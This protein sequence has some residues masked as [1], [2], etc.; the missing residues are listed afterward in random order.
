MARQLPLAYFYP[1]AH[2]DPGRLEERFEQ[3]RAA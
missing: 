1:V 3:F 2:P